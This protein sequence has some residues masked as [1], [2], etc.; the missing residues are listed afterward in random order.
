VDVAFLHQLVGAGD[1]LQP[2]DV[3]EVVGDLRAEN[4]AGSS[5]IDCP[6]FDVLGVRPHEIAEGPFVGD[7]DLAVDGPGL[8]DG[9]DFWGESA[10]DA[11]D[12][13]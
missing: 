4:P 12:L 5:G 2:V 7:L 3:A 13:S 11:E 8:V 6:I 10:V 1:E 9:L